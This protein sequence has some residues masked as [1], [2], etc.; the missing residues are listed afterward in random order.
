MVRPG[1][2]KGSE[3]RKADFPIE[4]LLR[5]RGFQFL[6]LTVLPGS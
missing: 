2:I 4:P 3:I 1:I 5:D 6:H